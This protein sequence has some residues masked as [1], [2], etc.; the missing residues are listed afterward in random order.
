MGA[1]RPPTFT[2]VKEMQILIDKYFKD[3]EG[4]VLKDKDENVILDKYGTPV[5]LGAK[6]LTITGLAL[7]LGFTSRQALLN[8]QGKEEY[9]DTV[10]RAKLI[11]EQYA[12]SRLFDKDGANGAKFALANNYKGWAEK[13][14]VAATN[15]NT[16]ININ[17]DDSSKLI[18]NAT[19]EEL[20]QI[21][22]GEMSPKQQQEII[23]RK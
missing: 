10:K 3:C 2:N 23:N 1:G 13:S 18:A 5:V 8:Y 15:L 6:P 4:T 7:A 21:A 16:N 17:E 12:E 20:E 9:F 11:V 14:E 19:Q 22:A